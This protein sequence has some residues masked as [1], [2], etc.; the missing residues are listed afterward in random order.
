MPNLL[1]LD[2]TG[3]AVLK[4]LIG[5]PTDEQV[6]TAVN[7]V[8]SAHPEWTTTVQDG[9]ITG[10]KIADDTI[11][12]AKLAQTGGVLSKVANI[13]GFLFTEVPNLFDP[14]NVIVGLR[15]VSS[16][17]KLQYYTDGGVPRSDYKTVR[18]AVDPETAY[19]AVRS[20]STYGVISTSPTY[21]DAAFMATV[22]NNPY[23]VTL[24]KSF[25]TSDTFVNFTTDANAQYLYL[26]YTITGEDATIAIYEGTYDNFQPAS[27]PNVYT[28]EQIDS[29]FAGSVYRDGINTII[30]NGKA[31]YT[32]RHVENAQINVDCYRIYECK[33]TDSGDTVWSGSDADGVVK[34]V[35]ESDF[36]GGLHG[37][38]ATTAMHML[39]DGVEVASGDFSKVEYSKLV[40]YC[41][42]TVY[43]R[44]AT[45]PAFT[46]YKVLT[47]DADG[48]RIQN[49]WVAAETVNVNLCYFGMLS[50]MRLC[51]DG[52]TPLING[53]SVSPIFELM[54]N[55]ETTVTA[56]GNDEAVMHTRYGDMSIK[57]NGPAGITNYGSVENYTTPDQRL[58]VYMGTVWTNGT[59][60]T[61]TAGEALMG[62]YRIRI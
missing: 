20:N 1:Y 50:V 18:V 4:T 43:H 39:I 34:L 51:S 60:K 28:K 16:G 9:S 8:L 33:L 12:D 49:R 5:E 61:F 36:I 40:V 45:T 24:A 29:G 38:E 54:G 3:V 25:T 32:L 42:S 10:P 2:D 15:T 46:R 55:T 48:V 30:T 37:D 26:C 52:T 27:V 56:E 31:T 22:G 62:D 21:I 6:T 13:D 53:Y 47:F 57:Y 14:A 35:G 41:E 59:G 7:A 58:K 19:T 44:D 11:Q 17:S 23:D